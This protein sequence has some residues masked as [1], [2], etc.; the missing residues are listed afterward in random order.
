MRKDSNAYIILFS[1]I[2]ILVSAIGL[3]YF[4]ESLKGTIASN[5]KKEKMT[6]ILKV[7]GI[8]GS[9]NL[10][11]VYKNSVKEVIIDET[12]K[13]VINSKIS[14]FGLDLTKQKREKKSNPSSVVMY[15]LYICKNGDKTIY[16]TETSGV[17]LWGAIWGYVAVNSDKNTIEGTYFDHKSE[18]PGLGAE[19]KESW[20]QEQFIG[21]KLSD[22]STFASISVLKKTEKTT[23]DEH[24]VDAISGATIT[25]NGVSVMLKDDLSVYVNYLNSLK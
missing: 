25:G 21:K 6:N 4:N 14:V 16:V 18:T 19:I 10:E 7:A 24:R 1:V 12:G 15:P 13:E 23:P 22:G 8:D 5:A 2:M 9:A 17:G 11:E 3:A 20:F